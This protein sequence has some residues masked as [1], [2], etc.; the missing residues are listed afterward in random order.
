MNEF[1]KL[2][3]K[4]VMFVKRTFENFSLEAEYLIMNDKTKEYRFS[5]H[6]IIRS[7]NLVKKYM[8]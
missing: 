7:Y 3:Q 6:G 1:M 4:I 2:S 5:L 8:N